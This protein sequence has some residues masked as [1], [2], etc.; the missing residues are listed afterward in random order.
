MFRLLVHLQGES[1]ENGI[2]VLN[3]KGKEGLLEYL[4]GYPQT[5]VDF[6]KIIYDKKNDWHC[7][8]NEYFL[9]CNILPVF[10]SLFID[11]KKNK[12]SR[13]KSLFGGLN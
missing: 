1:A 2:R 5:P 11:V 7:R 4:K 3:T 12:Y 10:C 8:L 13:Y 9:V 6:E